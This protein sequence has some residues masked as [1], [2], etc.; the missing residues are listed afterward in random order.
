MRI[1]TVVADSFR[2]GVTGWLPIFAIVLSFIRRALFVEFHSGSHRPWKRHLSYGDE[3][4]ILTLQL[5]SYILE[6]SIEG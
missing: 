2:I 1:E 6:R 4:P 5:L 3:Y